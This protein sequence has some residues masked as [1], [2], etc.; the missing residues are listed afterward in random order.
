MRTKTSL[1]E[2]EDE[3]ITRLDVDTITSSGKWGSVGHITQRKRGNHAQR[4]PQLNVST[5]F[6]LN[7]KQY[8][9]WKVAIY[10][11]IEEFDKATKAWEQGKA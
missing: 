7:Q 5:F 11:L 1:L 8:A 3:F 6:T 4:Q 2:T 10:L 9:D